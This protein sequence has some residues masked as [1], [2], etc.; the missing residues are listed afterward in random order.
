MPWT[1]EDRELN[2]TRLGHGLTTPY[3]LRIASFEIASRHFSIS[4][5][6][7]ALL[8]SIFKF[9]S[10]SEEYSGFSYPKLF[11]LPLEYLEVEF[12]P[13]F[14]LPL[15]LQEEALLFGLFFF[16]LNF[17]KQMSHYHL[18]IVYKLLLGLKISCCTCYARACFSIFLAISFGILAIYAK[19]FVSI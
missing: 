7:L 6:L 10:S 8:F 5:I 11:S 2:H 15:L 14:F 18:E 17:F 4:F 1:W 12:S 16:F 19:A 9:S 13:F 3:S